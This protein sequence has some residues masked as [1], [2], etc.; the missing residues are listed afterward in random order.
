MQKFYKAKSLRY[1]KRHMNMKRMKAIPTASIRIV[2]V[3]SLNGKYLK[4]TIS[5]GV[6]VVLNWGTLE[7]FLN[8]FLPHIILIY[9]NKYEKKQLYLYSYYKMY[10]FH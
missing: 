7:I 1:F 10:I 5:G 6:A 3:S 2:I 8:I 9:F 4:P